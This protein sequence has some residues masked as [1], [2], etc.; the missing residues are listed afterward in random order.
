MSPAPLDG[1]HAGGHNKHT[2]GI[3]LIGTDTFTIEQWQALD[4]LVEKMRE[5][6]PAARVLGHRDL[7]DVNKLCPGFDVAA[8]LARE[9][10]VPE[11][12]VLP[13]AAD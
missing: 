10:N 9:G 8:W 13:L 12:W 5:R 6:Y 11:E 2:I 4:G 3:C 1:A 7:P